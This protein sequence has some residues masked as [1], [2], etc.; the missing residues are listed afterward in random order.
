MDAGLSEELIQAARDAYS[1]GDYYL[2]Y[3]KKTEGDYIQGAVPGTTS[4]HNYDQVLEY[5]DKAEALFKE[6]KGTLK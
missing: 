5:Y 4:I 2:A 6:H 1:L 3:S